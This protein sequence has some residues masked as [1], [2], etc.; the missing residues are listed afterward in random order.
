MGL[1]GSRLEEL[2]LIAL[3]RIPRCTG[4][5]RYAALLAL[6]A[7]GRARDD[8]ARSLPAVPLYCSH[9]VCAPVAARLTHPSDLP[10]AG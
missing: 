5:P 2:E 7:A 6:H 9:Q 10:L 3:G 1:A 8:R 4:C